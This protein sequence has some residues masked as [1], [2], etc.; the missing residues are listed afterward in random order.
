MYA[1]SENVSKDA[2]IRTYFI[3]TKQLIKKE[4]SREREENRE[5]P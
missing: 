4:F 3:S 1:Q 5:K 2:R